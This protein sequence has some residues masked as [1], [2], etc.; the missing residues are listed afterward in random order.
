LISVFPDGFRA[1]F[2]P[3]AALPALLDM[4]VVPGLVPIALPDVVPVAVDPDV[5]PLAAAPPV[6]EP[7]PAEPP[8]DCANAEAPVRASAAASPNVAS[9]MVAPCCCCT[10]ANEVRQRCVPAGRS[11]FVAFSVEDFGG[12]RCDALEGITGVASRYFTLRNNQRL[13]N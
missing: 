1:L 2:A 6:D 8:L 9:F 5:V 7:P 11:Q 3:A 10:T 13:F 12:H 4:P